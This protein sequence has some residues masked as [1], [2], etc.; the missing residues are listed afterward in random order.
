MSDPNTHRLSQRTVDDFG[1]QWTRFTSN[2]GFYGSFALFEDMC[3]PLL[4]VAEVR[5]LRTAE[6][7]SGT[8]RIVQMLL[9]AGAA[10]VVAL[11]PSAAFEVLRRNVAKYGDR[12]ACLRATGE[13]LPRDG[14]YD[15]VVS[16]GVL[17]H[18]PEPAPVVR[19]AYEALKPGGRMLVWLYGREGNWTYLALTLPLRVITTR[20]PHAALLP[21]ARLLTVALKPYIWLSRRVS[22]PLSGY[23]ANVFGPMDHDKQVLII[24]DQLRPAY[25]RYY[26]R[27]QAIGLLS[28]AGFHDVQ[29]HHRHGYSWTVIGTKR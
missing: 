8:G 17:H 18:I 12:V 23:F 26:T 14:R 24:Y 27:A 6:I 15:L 20:L 10:H 1:D 4:D 16:I 13:Q 28:A 7:G 22:I 2:E 19:A 25:A 21:L 9:A 29:S 5:G 3:G 11:E